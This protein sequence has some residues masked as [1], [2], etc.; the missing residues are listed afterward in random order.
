MNK[1]RTISQE[2]KMAARKA[3][4]RI[5]VGVF[6]FALSTAGIAVAQAQ[7]PATKGN[8]PPAAAS[9]PGEPVLTTATYGDWILRCVRAGDG[10][11]GP[12]TCEVVQ[13][14]VL[15]NQQA[16]IAQI[17]IGS[18]DKTSGLRL[19]IVVPVAV[20]LGKGPTITGTGSSVLFDLSWRRCLPSG[21][22]ADISLTPEA[23]KM[24]RARAEP[25]TLTFRDSAESDVNLPFS[26]RG[27]AQALDAFPK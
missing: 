21:C 1:N 24:L 22:Y 6:M 3:A 13:S 19:T 23:V 8:T 20:S 16:P 10:G 26:M 15:P 4:Q 14:I 11:T 17:A 9:V 27:F 5:A 12:Q 7:T 25:A 2:K 18:V